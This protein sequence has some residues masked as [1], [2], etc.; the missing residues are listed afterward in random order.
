MMKLAGAGGGGGILKM[1][2]FWKRLFLLSFTEHHEVKAY[3]GSGEYPRS[4]LTSAL[5][6]IELS[7]SRPG[8]FTLGQPPPPRKTSCGSHCQSE[9]LR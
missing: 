7:N 6:A 1:L 5:D 9:L 4:S 8:R 2:I 3:G